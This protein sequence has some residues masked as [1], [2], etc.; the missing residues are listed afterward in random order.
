[1]EPPPDTDHWMV[2]PLELEAEN[3]KLWPGATAAT[4]GVMVMVPVVTGVGGGGGAGGL[5]GVGS[6]VDDDVGA[7]G[8]KEQEDED[9]GG[10]QERLTPAE[11]PA[12]EGWGSAHR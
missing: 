6:P 5:G 8:E 3:W 4:V 2:P 9:R 11:E 1:M 7:A 10:G 12:M